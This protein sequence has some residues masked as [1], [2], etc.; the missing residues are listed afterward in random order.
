MMLNETLRV[1]VIES[2]IVGSWLYSLLD[3][4][5]RALSSLVG[6]C[7]VAWIALGNQKR[8]NVVFATVLI[9]ALVTFAIHPTLDS[10]CASLKGSLPEPM[11]RYADPYPFK[12]NVLIYAAF[13]EPTIAAFVMISVCWPALGGSAL[14]RI[15]AFTALL[16]LVRGRI[17]GLFVESFW[18]K[19]PLPRAFLAESQF[20]L[21]T[22]ALGLLVALAWAYAARIQCR[23]DR[24]MEGD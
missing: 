19:Q 18:V 10:L 14:R 13:I 15:L 4:A 9:A 23:V 1:L 3:I 17:V 11:P 5:P 24:V 21:E 20:F 7:A 8:R 22:L 2:T 12:I 6:G 16:L